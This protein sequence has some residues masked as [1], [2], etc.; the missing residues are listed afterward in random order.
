MGLGVECI[1]LAD[2]GAVARLLALPRRVQLI[3]YL[4]LGIPQAFHVRPKRAAGD[5]RARR[6]LDSRIYTDSWG[7]TAERLADAMPP[8]D[9]HAPRG[10]ERPCST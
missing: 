6:R 7:Q 5:W 4:C 1:R 8:A 9:D 3:A 10:E 2:D